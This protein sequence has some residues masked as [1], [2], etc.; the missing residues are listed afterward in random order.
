MGL[1]EGVG[2]LRD[3]PSELSQPG[4]DEE[5]DFRGTVCVGRENEREA[6]SQGVN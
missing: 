5:G 6:C 4:G 3:V 1:G 2:H